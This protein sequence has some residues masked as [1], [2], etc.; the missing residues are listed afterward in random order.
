MRGI[1]YQRLMDLVRRENAKVFLLERTVECSSRELQ[2]RTEHHCDVREE[3]TMFHRRCG[4][5]NRMEAVHKK[6]L[7]WIAHRASRSMQTKDELLLLAKNAQHKVKRAQRDLDDA[8]NPLA[9]AFCEQR[10]F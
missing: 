10:M 5:V 7:G 6:L 8:N 4:A 3:L 9:K 2:V 1:E